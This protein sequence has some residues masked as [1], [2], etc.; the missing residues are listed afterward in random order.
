MTSAYCRS[1][2]RYWLTRALAYMRAG[3]LRQFNACL[4]HFQSWKLREINH[5]TI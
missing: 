4:I 1:I 5:G 2:S 3:K